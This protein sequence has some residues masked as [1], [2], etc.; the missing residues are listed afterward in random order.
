MKKGFTLAEMLITVAVATVIGLPLLA[1]VGA[2]DKQTIVSEDYMFAESLAQ[3][4]LART[5]AIPLGKLCLP[6]DEAIDLTPPEDE[7]IVEPYAA[8][9]K[10][11]S[12]DYSFAGNVRVE[13]VADGLYL[14]TIEITWPIAPGSDEDRRLTLTR[15]RCLPT[16]SLTRTFRQSRAAALRRKLRQ[17]P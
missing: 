5:M 15:Y 3:R 13:E 14:Y 17:N 6:I 10:N 12:G 7:K 2:S 11:L 16:L 1:I 9:K 4:H 8:Y